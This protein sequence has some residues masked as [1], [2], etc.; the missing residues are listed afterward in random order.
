MALQE[1]TEVGVC[2]GRTQATQIPRGLLQVL[3]QE[4]RG[5]H[6]ILCFTP[7]FLRRLLRVM[8]QG[9]ATGL[10]LHFQETLG[11]LMLLLIQFME[12]VAHTLHCHVVKVEME[13]QREGGVGG[14]QM[15]ADQAVMTVASTLV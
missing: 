4:K 3:L 6:N 11:A 15:H 8:G 10:V 1:A 5:F 14:L 2:M 7:L 13:A 9:V 12:K